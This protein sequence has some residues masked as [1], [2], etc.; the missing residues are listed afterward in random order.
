MAIQL[1]DTHPSLAIPELMRILVDE[2]R[3]EWEKVG[4][5]TPPSTP[6]SP[7]LSQ[8][9]LPSLGGWKDVGGAPPPNRQQC[10][11]QR[12]SVLEPGK[13]AAGPRLLA[14]QCVCRAMELTPGGS[15]LPI[16]QAWDV[17]VRTCAYTNHTVLP[18]ALERW[19]VHLMETLLP[20]HL[21]IIYEINQRFLNVSLCV[22][23]GG[24]WR[25][26]GG[27]WGGCGEDG[28]EGL[29]PEALAGTAMA[30]LWA[31]GPGAPGPSLALSSA[32]TARGGRVPWGCRPA[33]AHVSGGGGRREAHQHGAPVHRRLARRQRR[34]SHPL[35]DPQEDHVRP[36]PPILPLPLPPPPTPP[37]CP[38]PAAPGRPRPGASF[39]PGGPHVTPLTHRTLFTSPPLTSRNQGRSSRGGAVETNPTRNREVASSI[40]GLAQGVKDLHGPE[41]WCRLKMRPGSCVALA[42]V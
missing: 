26:G 6:T 21:Q 42:G 16:P 32:G 10:E 25:W 20:R 35:R 2:E 40:P 38:A 8:G 1:N 34:G 7:S 5:R 27:G 11:A 41:L 19:P 17:T 15:F 31:G 13:A 39:K 36:A 22:C 30:G 9:P 12:A 29:A 24:C 18:E 37:H 3:L 23:V 33:A 4:L 14:A 28:M